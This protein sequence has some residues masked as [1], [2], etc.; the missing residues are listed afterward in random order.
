MQV[1]GQLPARLTAEHVAWVLNC[2]PPLFPLTDCR[3]K[4]IR[5]CDPSYP[6]IPDEGKV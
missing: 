6:V 3:P 1:L 4:T 2:Q 5:D